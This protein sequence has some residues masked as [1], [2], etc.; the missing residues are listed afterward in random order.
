MFKILLDE[1]KITPRTSKTFIKMF[2]GDN[3]DR[4]RDLIRED[5]VR[6]K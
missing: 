3:S 1:F 6:S 4:V 2:I 5:F